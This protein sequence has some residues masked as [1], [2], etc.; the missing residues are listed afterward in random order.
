MLLK[1][2]TMRNGPPARQK[3]AG[4]KTA[5]ASR[6]KPAAK[7]RVAA[8]RGKAPAAATAMNGKG[9]NGNATN[10]NKTR[11]RILDVATQEFSAK[12][13]DGARIDDI[14]R[15][16]KVSKNLI[17]HYFVSKEKLFIAVLEQ[18]YQ[19]MHAYQMTWPLDVSSPV[20]GIRK[21]VRSTK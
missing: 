16:S 1:A 6:A 17:Y 3:P 12:G 13:Y 4:K 11:Q 10:G 9:M 21:L 20:D 8:S 7:P 14:M 5:P 19:S 18:A 2:K 15:L